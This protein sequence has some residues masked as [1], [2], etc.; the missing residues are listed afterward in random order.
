MYKLCRILTGR[1]QSPDTSHRAI[2]ISHF[3]P[4]G[5]G[6]GGED[7]I[8]PVGDDSGLDILL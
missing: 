7:S 8:R 3:V 5:T 1:L 4:Y 6:R 2:G